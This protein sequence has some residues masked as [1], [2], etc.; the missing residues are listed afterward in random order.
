M[1]KLFCSIRMEGK[2]MKKKGI[3]SF[4]LVLCLCM[5]WSGN[6]QAAPFE[7]IN[8]NEQ[9]VIDAAATTKYE[10]KG[11]L[12]VTTPSGMAALKRDMQ[13]RDLDSDAAD[14]LISGDLISDAEMEK[15][16]AQGYVEVYKENSGLGE[17]GSSNDDTTPPSGNEGNLG[18]PENGSGNGSGGGG[19][20]PDNGLGNGSGGGGS[21][22]D[23]GSSNGSGGGGSNPDNGSSNGS[24]GGESNPGNGSGNGSGGGASN[25][26]NGSGS[27][28]SNLGNGSGNGSGGGASQI[29]PQT[30]DGKSQSIWNAIISDLNMNKNIASDEKGT[31]NNNSNTAS[32]DSSSEDSSEDTSSTKSTT[33]SPLTSAVKETLG[34]MEEDNKAKSKLSSYKMLS[35]QD[36]GVKIISETGS[37]KIVDKKGKTILSYDDSNKNS[38]GIEGSIIHVEW[39]IPLALVLLFISILCIYIE[40]KQGYYLRE[41]KKE[42][43]QKI[44]V[45]LKVV[46]EFILVVNILSIFL[47]SVL[48]SGMFR[49]SSVMQALNNSTYYEYSYAQMAENTVRILAENDVDPLALENTLQ[50]DDFVLVIKQQIEKQ[51]STLDETMAMEKTKEN[52]DTEINNYYKTEEEK[53]LK[54][55]GVTETKKEKKERKIK[56]R[57]KSNIITNS[58]MANY[59]KYADFYPAHLLRQVKRDFRAV[60]QVV[61]P[62][63]ALNMLINMVGI[64]HLYRRRYKGIGGIGKSVAVSAVLSF[65]ASI[66]LFVKKPYTAFYLSPEYLYHFVL[67]YCDNA[68]KTSVILSGLLLGIALI[69]FIFNQIMFPRKTRV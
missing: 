31:S 18:N 2:R 14:K 65:F 42:V 6:A 40:F 47:S 23:N 7:V 58:I 24:G 45:F 60:A 28:A 48:F 56:R 17:E 8:E 55:A 37:V 20:N 41:R 54:E 12:Y 67:S 35:E 59:K 29:A 68:V 10:Y 16:I 43:N 61:F 25:S 39:T 26:G 9:R 57:E 33:L 52:I 50:Y 44:R 66:F 32:N 4:F 36:A 5:F 30:S 51:L 62:I 63:A 34:L 13:R 15:R 46:M 49:S 53:Q 21:N 38:Q 64:Y 11:Q 19:S 3:L 1:D 22:P 27:G 69:I